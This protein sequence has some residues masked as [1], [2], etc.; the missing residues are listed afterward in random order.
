MA[1]RFP[2]QANPDP[3]GDLKIALDTL[4]NHPNLP[5]FFCKQMIQH[6]VTSNPSPAYVGRVAAVFQDNGPG[7]SRRHEGRDPRRFC[8]TMKRATPL[9]R[10]AIRNTARCARR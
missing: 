10:A 1:L 6:L 9:R 2:T 7:R 8:W 3:D 5:P 4:F